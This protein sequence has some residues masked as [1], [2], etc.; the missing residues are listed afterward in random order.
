MTTSA[1]GIFAVN[2]LINRFEQM[3]VSICVLKRSDGSR[4]RRRISLALNGTKRVDPLGLRQLKI[5]LNGRC[6]EAKNST[7][8]R[9]A[10]FV[11]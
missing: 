11:T 7:V 10:D 6:L 3:G 5:P 2:I 9:V 1:H 4:Q 8:K